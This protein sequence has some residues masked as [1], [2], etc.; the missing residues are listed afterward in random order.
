MNKYWERENCADIQA[1]N[2]IYPIQV[3]AALWC[4]VPFNLVDQYLSIATEISPSIFKH[5]NIKCLEAKC[6]AMQNAILA[7]ELP[8]SR[9]NGIEVTDHIGDFQDSCRVR[10]V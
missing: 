2:S 7:K 4:G 6:R 10:H 5:P 1:Y 9:E 3:A 8:V